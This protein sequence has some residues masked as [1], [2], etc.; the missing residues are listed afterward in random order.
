M[1]WVRSVLGPNCPYTPTNVYLLRRSVC[2]PDS[3]LPSGYLEF[4]T[5]YE[6]M[7]LGD[8]KRTVPIFT[9]S[10]MYTQC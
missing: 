5:C 10:K 9:L 1:S 8:F 4:Y 2:Q 6:F 7:I 3:V